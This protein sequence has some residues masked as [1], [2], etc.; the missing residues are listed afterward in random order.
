MDNKAYVLAYTV[1]A[2][3]TGVDA[4]T[5]GFRGDVGSAGIMTAAAILNGLQ[6]FRSAANEIA[7]Y[8][9]MR[10]QRRAFQHR[11]GGHA[12]PEP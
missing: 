3:I 4:V 2:A 8:T 9:E 5:A 12:T 6:A 7:S 11:C 1:L 10:A